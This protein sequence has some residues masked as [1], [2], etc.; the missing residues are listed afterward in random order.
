VDKVISMIRDHGK[1]PTALHRDIYKGRAFRSGMRC[2]LID[3]AA[4]SWS[5]E[6]LADQPGD[7]ECAEFFRD[8]GVAAMKRMNDAA[9]A[10]YSRK[11]VGCHY[12]DH[13]WRPC[14]IWS[15]K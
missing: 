5:S 11:D 8:V 3:I 12:H 7:P 4:Y 14:Y 15:F 9:I 1:V 2:L 6:T 13:V 10:P